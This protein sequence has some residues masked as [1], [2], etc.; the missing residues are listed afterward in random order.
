MENMT[1][2]NRSTRSM[3]EQYINGGRE[4]VEK[5]HLER[6][7]DFRKGLSVYDLK[8]CE[9]T[10]GDCSK[11][12][13]HNASG[14]PLDYDKEN[15]K[16][17][18]DGSDAHTLLIGSTGS[19][20]TRLVGMPIVLALAS[21][22]ENMIICDPKGEIFKRTSG[23]LQDNDYNTNVINLRNPLQGDGWNMLEIPYRK[24]CEGD[25]D[26]AC[27]FINDMTIN[28][29]PIQARDPYWDYSARDVL[30]GLILLLFKLGVELALPNGS[31]SMKSVLRLRR[32]L[33]RSSDSQLIQNTKLWEFAK[34]D[35]LIH[36]RL[37]GTVICP[38]KTMA[39]IISTFDQHMSCFSLQP[40][41]IDMLSNSTF[42]VNRFGFEKRALYLIMPDEKTTYHR[43]I[44]IITKQIYELLIDNA[45]K[46][47]KDNRFDTR[48]NFVLDEFSSLPTISDMPQMI[49]ASRSRNIRFHLIVQ[50]RHQLAQRYGEE[51]ETI[52]SNCA[53]W[54]FLTSR[55][56]GLIK[57]ISE[58]CGTVGRDREPLVS[59]SRLQHMN[60]QTGECLILSGRKYPY[61]AFL[62]DI[63]LYDNK[64]Y[65]TIELARR[66][67][68]D[69]TYK[70]FGYYEKAVKEW[71]KHDE[72]SNS[73]AVQIED[74]NSQELD[75]IRKELEAKFDELFGPLDSDD[76]QPSSSSADK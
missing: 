17:Y 3:Y 8:S 40:Q 13:L 15:R 10:V 7:E 1:N 33:F 21:S 25:I 24:Y 26:K 48:I 42:D 55:E 62:P 60:K 68:P 14:V 6:K 53:N 58:L 52:M 30:F 76:N 36:A 65:H 57:D 49:A 51:T 72:M 39:C 27:E 32:E 46:L 64:E 47:T 37:Y 22:S 4:I 20:K 2:K 73:E 71:L 75:E 18:I 67:V 69:D 28:L 16:V 9:L 43:I 35:E 38:E 54:I 74:N 50:S 29:M 34:R 23:V 31:V 70:G 11:W 59:V 41:M 56:L 5:N 44:T 45:Y 19:K 12:D 63:D 66:T 61:F